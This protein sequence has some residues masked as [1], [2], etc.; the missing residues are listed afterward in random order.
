MRGR[1]V[2]ERSKQNEGEDLK[3]GVGGLVDLE[4][5]VQTVQLR[6]GSKFKWLI[7]SSTFEAV[8][9]LVGRNVLKQGDVRKIEKNLG[10]LRRLEACIRMNSETA[11]FV[12]PA[13]KDRLQAVVAAMGNTT[14]GA[15]RKALQQTRKLNRKLFATTLRSIPK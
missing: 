8:A 10:Y 15:F 12:L 11:D 6:Y 14:P 13:E 2:K 3:V 5:L 7:R 9:S 4:F 1:M